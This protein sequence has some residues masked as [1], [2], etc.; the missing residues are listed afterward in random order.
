MNVKK[1]LRLENLV[2]FVPC[3]VPSQILERKERISSGEIDPKSLSPKAAEN[4]GR[5]NS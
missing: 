1:A 5:R 2:R 3:F 4:L